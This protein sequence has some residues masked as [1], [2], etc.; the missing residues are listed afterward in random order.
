MLSSCECGAEAEHVERQL[1]DVRAE[2]KRLVAALADKGGAPD[3]VSPDL[4]RSF[5]TLRDTES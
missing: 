5:L 1:E 2:Q 3:G 4:L